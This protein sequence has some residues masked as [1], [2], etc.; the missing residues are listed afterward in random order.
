MMIH[1][2]WETT[3]SRGYTEILEVRRIGTFCDCISVSPP[4]SRARPSHTSPSDLVWKTTDFAQTTLVVLDNKQ[5]LGQA[6]RNR[7][8]T[9]TFKTL[10]A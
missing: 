10:S 9:G 4:P 5:T 6:R 1:K 7:T 8:L 2:D 3:R